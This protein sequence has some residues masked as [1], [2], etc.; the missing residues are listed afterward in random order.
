MKKEILIGILAGVLLFIILMASL[1]VSINS[2]RGSQEGFT[3]TEKAVI[4]VEMDDAKKKAM[5]ESEII[6]D[7]CRENLISYNEGKQT[8]LYVN[9]E[10]QIIERNRNGEITDNAALLKYNDLL[11]EETGSIRN[12]KYASE[13]GNISYIYDDDLYYF[14][15]ATGQSNKI[16]NDCASSSGCDMYWIQPEKIYF[17]SYEEEKIQYSLY[18]QNEQQE[19]ALVEGGIRSFCVNDCGTKLY[20]VQGYIIPHAFGFSQEY[21]IVEIDLLQNTVHILAEVEGDDLILGDIDNQFLLYAEEDYKKK[22]T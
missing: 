22:I 8:F 3:D 9:Q 19:I 6:F 15:Y 1:V 2:S 13:E 20:G 4:C 17:I 10:N 11:K 12:L 16:V 21:R 7:D 5:V 14:D 18:V